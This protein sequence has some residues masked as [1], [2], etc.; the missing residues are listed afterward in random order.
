[1]IIEAGY[2]LH[3]IIH[4]NMHSRK[5]PWALWL[6]SM[7]QDLRLLRIRK[8]DSDFGDS[9]ER[10]IDRI[11]KKLVGTSVSMQPKYFALAHRRERKDGA[12]WSDWVHE[13]DQLVHAAPQLS[14]YRYLGRMVFN[15]TWVYSSWPRYS[16]RDYVGCEDLPRVA[17]IPG[18]HD[19]GC[20]CLACVQFNDRIEAA[21]ASRA[22]GETTQSGTTD[23]P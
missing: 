22:V 19:W 8:I 17:A 15:R 2:D 21:R 20:P 4:P 10:H 6:I 16:F 18:P 5:N 1:V 9:V 14:D 3:Q 7:D 23:A 13:D 11:A 12:D